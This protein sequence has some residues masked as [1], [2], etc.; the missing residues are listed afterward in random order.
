MTYD[1]TMRGYTC[2]MVL[3]QGYYNF[4]FVTLD[5]TTGVIA[6]E[7]TAG[8]HWE[9]DNVYKLYFYY[10]NSIKGYDELIGYSVVNS[11]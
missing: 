7:L 8:N 3:K 5:R 9:T 2:S 10:F 4:M 11:H 6:T 1:Y